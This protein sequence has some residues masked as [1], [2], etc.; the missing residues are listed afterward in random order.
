VRTVAFETH[1]GGTFPFWSCGGRTAAF[2]NCTTLAL[3]FNTDSSVLVVFARIAVRFL[4]SFIEGFSISA[5]MGELMRVELRDL[6][7]TTGF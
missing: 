3:V 6:V 4:M 2:L 7:G 5:P 1:R